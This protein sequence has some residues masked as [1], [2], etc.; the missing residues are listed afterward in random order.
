MLRLPSNLPPA[1]SQGKTALVGWGDVGCVPG[2]AGKFE[3]LYNLCTSAIRG[4]TFP[5][6]SGGG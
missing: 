2:F 1:G 3:Q 5:E 4:V 6:L